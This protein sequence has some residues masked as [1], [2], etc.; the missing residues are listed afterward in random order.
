MTR[1]G[2]QDHDHFDEIIEN[3]IKMVIIL[4]TYC[5]HHRHGWH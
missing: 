2:D 5:G 3:L 4:V 1:I